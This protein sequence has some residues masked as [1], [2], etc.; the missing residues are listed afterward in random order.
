MSAF[1]TSIYTRLTKRRE[2]NET[3]KHITEVWT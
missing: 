2:H 1:Q 3:N